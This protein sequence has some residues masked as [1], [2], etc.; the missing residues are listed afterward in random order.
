MGSHNKHMSFQILLFVSN[1]IPPLI[2]ITS[3]NPIK[4]FRAA[5]N[6]CPMTLKKAIHIHISPHI[7]RISQKL[8]QHWTNQFL[9]VKLNSLFSIISCDIPVR[10]IRSLIHLKN[11]PHNCSLLRLLHQLL[12]MN[13]FHYDLLKPVAIRRLSSHPESPLASG[14]ISVTDTLLDCLTFKLSKHNTDI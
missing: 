6:I 1:G 4:L 10:S 3:M 14:I 8:C 7:H 9:S 2:Q 12:C 13:P 11:F 5:D